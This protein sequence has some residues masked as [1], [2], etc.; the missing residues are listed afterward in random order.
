MTEL[1][2]YSIPVWMAL[3][4]L[5]FMCLVQAMPRP[6]AMSSQVYVWA[7]QFLHLLCMN[8]ALVADPAKKLKRE[9]P[10]SDSVLKP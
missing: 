10:F 4:Y 5:I 6:A 2:N 9:L 1:L 7:Y 8:L 3:V